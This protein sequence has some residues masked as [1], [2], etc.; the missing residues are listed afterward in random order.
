VV[1]DEAGTDIATAFVQSEVHIDRSA[2]EF[3]TCGC[4]ADIVL[5]TSACVEA[6]VHA[7]RFTPSLIRSAHGPRLYL[8]SCTHLHVMMQL[9]A[10]SVNDLVELKELQHTALVPLSDGSF[11][12]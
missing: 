8:I 12:D 10:L 4:N 5:S 7:F 11:Q 3:I 2:I 6:L 1:R 9:A